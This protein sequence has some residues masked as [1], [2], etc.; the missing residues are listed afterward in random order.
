[1]NCQSVF[2]DDVP[3]KLNEALVVGKEGNLAL[4]SQLSHQLQRCG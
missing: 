2:G 3:S 1:M 4:G